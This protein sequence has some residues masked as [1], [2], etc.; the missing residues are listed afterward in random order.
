MFT[1]RVSYLCYKKRNKE[2]TIEKYFHVFFGCYIDILS[3][4][5]F[6]ALWLLITK[7]QVT[8]VSYNIDAMIIAVALYLIYRFRNFNRLL[9]LKIK[10]CNQNTK[11]SDL[12]AHYTRLTRLVKIIDDD[13]NPF[14]F[15]SFSS[16]L[17]FNCKMIYDFIQRQKN[18]T[19]NS[20]NQDCD[21]A[22]S[23][24]V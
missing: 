21:I 19:A 7:F 1:S 6:T 5:Y 24:N 3:F 13:M 8:L 23:S 18:Y 17:V 9:R 4:N 15:V 14:V 2:L 10:K 12:Q 22:N 11:W 20:N 16:S